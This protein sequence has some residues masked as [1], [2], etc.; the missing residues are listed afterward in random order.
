MAADV[1][2]ARGERL[3]TSESENQDLFWGLR[4]GGGNFGVVSSFTFRAYPLGP[5]VFGANL[6][7]SRRRWAQPLRA[8]ARWTADLPDEL[9]S[10]VTFMVPPRDWEL[11]DEV[12]MI[13]GAAWSGSDHAEP[14]ALVARLREAAPPDGEVVEPT[15]WTAWQSAA[16]GCSRAASVPTGRTRR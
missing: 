6:F 8:Y 4:G 10:I 5:S 13:V 3:R 1:V 14:A 9:T 11:G 15:I 2:T 16:A 12:L 7:Y